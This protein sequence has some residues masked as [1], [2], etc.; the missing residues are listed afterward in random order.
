MKKLLSLLQKNKGYF[1][2]LTLFL[3]L[4]G[5]IFHYHPDITARLYG[6]H[7][8]S[9]QPYFIYLFYPILGIFTLVKWK[10]ISSMKPYKNSLWQTILF[11]L[12]ALI[13]FLIP[14]KGWLLQYYHVQNVIPLQ[15]IYYFP[16]FLGYTCLFIGLFNFNFVRR[17]E[18]ELFLL[19]YTAC[20]Y[21]VAEVLIEK[22]WFYFSDTILAALG[23]FLPLISK[24]VVVDPS[25]LMVKMEEFS[26]NIGAT[27]SGIYSL[28]T[29]SFLFVTSLVLIHK[30]ANIKKLQAFIAYIIGLG[31]LYALN[32]VRIAIIITVGAFYSPDLAIELFHEYLSA[33]FLIGLFLL[34]LY[35]VFPKI[36]KKPL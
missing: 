1:I 19:I 23:S 34:Y 24:T 18:S 30:K 10:E 14:V 7:T 17:F 13:I 4:Y 26:V 16:M 36:I 31:I 33:I 32:I 12:L 20:L 22:F 6:Y 27:C 9:Y 15:F 3:T 25:Q 11:S 28:T 29:F 21:L 8:E 5:L 2:R 35:H